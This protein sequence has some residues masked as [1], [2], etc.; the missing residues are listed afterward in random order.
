M[1]A[2]TLESDEKDTDH[3][4]DMVG[5]A[6]TVSVPREAGV[7][8]RLL[9]QG[10]PLT[11]LQSRTIAQPA[12]PHPPSSTVPNY[13]SQLGEEHAPDDGRLR[14]REFPTRTHAGGALVMPLTREPETLSRKLFL[15]RGVAASHG[16]RSHYGK[17]RSCG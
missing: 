4:L 6:T 10:T 9:D 16:S 14:T 5:T 7:P 8:R 15:A 12:A 17:S 2:Q 13:L 1:F 3:H 11:V